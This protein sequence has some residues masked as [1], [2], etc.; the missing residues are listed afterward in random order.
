MLGRELPAGGGPA[1]RRR[2]GP[3]RRHPAARLHG[4]LGGRPAGRALRDDLRHQRLLGRPCRCS[5]AP[6]TTSQDDA[7]LAMFRFQRRINRLALSH[8]AKL[9]KYLGD[10]A[11]YSS[12]EATN[13]LLCSIHL[14]RYYVQA[15]ARGAP[16]RPRHAHRPQLRPLPPDPD[17]RPAASEGERYEFFGPGLVELSRLTTG[18]ATQEIDEVKT[19]LDQPGLSRGDRAP[20][21][22]PAGAQE[23]RRGGQEGGGAPLLRL[24][25]PNGTLHNNGMVATG[26]FIAQLDHE[27]AGGRLYR[28]RERGPAPTSS[29][30]QDDGGERRGR[31]PQARHR[32]TSRGSKSWPSTRSWT[33]R[34][35]RSCRRSRASPARRR[36]PAESAEHALEE[37]GAGQAIGALHGLYK[38]S[39]GESSG[40]ASSPGCRRRGAA[41]CATST[42]SATRC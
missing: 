11:F 33:P 30:V 28:G 25:Q 4:A 13:L 42:I 3:L 7:F 41:R 16:L 22:R 6:A 5:T 34:R 27:T 36:R 40:R 1:A 35:S 10:G 2:A 21:L 23:R 8:R 14:Q 20:L 9:E 31:G 12:R 39:H 32:R 18:K 37:L 38:R 15:R 19:M 24:H 17:G 29:S 26:P